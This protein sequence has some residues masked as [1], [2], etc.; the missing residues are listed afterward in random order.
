MRIAFA[1]KPLRRHKQH[2][3]EFMMS[4]W[5]TLSL[6]A[7]AIG[8]VGKK[9]TSPATQ[10]SSHAE[11][12]QSVK[13]GQ[14]PPGGHGQMEMPTPRKLVVGTAPAYPRAGAMTKLVLQIQDDDGT[15]IKR[16]E[17]LHEQLIHLILVRDGLDEFAHL[18]PQVDKMGMITT[19]FAF[20]KSGN[21][22]LFAD[23][24]PQGKSASVASG[25]LVVAGDDEPAERLMPNASPVVAVGEL[26]AHV[27]VKSGD[28]EPMVRLHLADAAGRTVD[29]LQPYLGAMG[30][31]VI[32]SA[33]GSEYLHAHPV[34]EAQ[35]APE[36]VVEFAA[37][38]PKAGIYKAWGQFRRH[39]SILIVPFVM[40]H[41]RGPAH[42]HAGGH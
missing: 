33:D 12:T 21:Y 16:F 30:H 3:E 8:C 5:I 27:T 31:L 42:P 36:G 2:F 41:K 15:P 20:P 29:D 24:Q 37:H 35:A 38:F 4:A 11:G 14:S 10:S 9:E 23:H 19:E 13:N 6:I 32:I 17:M 39:N 18:H 7:V 22:R 40:E 34:N 1:A 25:E 26:R 28:Q